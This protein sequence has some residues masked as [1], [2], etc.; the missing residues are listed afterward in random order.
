VV[1]A[2]VNDLRV[3]PVLGLPW[4]QVGVGGRTAIQG[5]GAV[6]EDEQTAKNRLLTVY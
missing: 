5:E 4:R 2:D 3:H 1:L 6:G